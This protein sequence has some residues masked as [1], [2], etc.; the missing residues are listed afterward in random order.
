MITCPQCGS[1]NLPGMAYCEQCGS[2]LPQEVAAPATT[3]APTTTS[4]TLAATV[5]PAAASL[6]QPVMPVDQPAV[7]PT[8]GPSVGV[9]DEDAIADVNVV[10]STSSLGANVVDAD[11]DRVDASPLTPAP[12]A[13]GVGML[14]VTFPNGQTFTLSGDYADVGRADVAQNWRPALDV[15]PFGGGAPDLG[16]SRHHARISHDA[17]AYLVTD[18]GSTN[19]TY[20]NGR[21]VDPNQPAPLHDGDTLS[22]GALNTRVSIT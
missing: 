5:D 13:A 4:A 6:P 11:V 1:Q 9:A 3:A 7:Q 18:V 8:A 20:V 16:V 14:T 10:D 17:D 12:L 15:I 22:F 2:P 21:G 19:G